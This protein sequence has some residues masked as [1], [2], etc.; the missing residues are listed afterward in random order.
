MN[1]RQATKW[2]ARERKENKLMVRRARTMKPHM[3]PRWRQWY[4]VFFMR[5]EAE[6]KK[7]WDWR[8]LQGEFEGS[9]ED[10]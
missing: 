10:D 4:K 2:R 6:L 9:W 7:E 1:R 5:W 3:K 8:F